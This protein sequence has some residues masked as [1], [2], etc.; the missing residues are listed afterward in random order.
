MKAIEVSIRQVNEMRIS[1][2]EQIQVDILERLN[3][4]TSLLRMLQEEK[5]IIFIEIKP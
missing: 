3:N 4:L 1:E 5:N 2:G